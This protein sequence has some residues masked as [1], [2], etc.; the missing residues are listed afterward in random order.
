MITMST[1]GKNGAMGNQLFQYAVLYGISK[2][3][4]FEMRIPPP[5]DDVHGD[6]QIIGH[7]DKGNPI[8]KYDYSLGFF[9]ITSKHLS[10]R[11]MQ[12][13]SRINHQN[14]KIGIFDRFYRNR[15]KYKYCESQ[16]HFDPDI[17]S[18]KDGTDIEGYFQSEKYFS[19]CANAIRKEYSVKNR[20][21]EDAQFILNKYR[22]NSD[23]IISA[24]VRRAG[25]ELPE[26][27]HAHKY[28][29]EIYYQNAMDYFRS[30]FSKLKFLFFSD[31]IAW[32]KSKFIGKD[33]VFSENNSS[34]IDFTMMSHCDHN[35]I[36][37]SSFSW[38]ASW[39]NINEEKIVIVPDGDLF[40]P[41]GPKIS[42]DYF[43]N[44]VRRISVEKVG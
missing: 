42:R 20:Y 16:F 43:P 11:E 31:D 37:P 7:T 1:L 39:L 13:I 2:K 28:P 24:H 17:F 10:N 41:E 3:T 25:H 6:F 32:C 30:K 38:W 15:I 34:I 12:S 29:D 22:S 18:I 5:P 4:G 19:H 33:I 9:N 35:I 23:Q 26:Y 27:Q 44:S 21:L 8:E 14:R 40:G 36:T